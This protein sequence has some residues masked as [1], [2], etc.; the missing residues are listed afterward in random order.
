MGKNVEIKA[1]CS[2]LVTVAKKIEENGGMF[3]SAA[4]SRQTDVYLHATSGRLKIRFHDGEGAQRAEVIQYERENIPGQKSAS[5]QVQPLPPEAARILTSCLGQKTIV[6]KTRD[7]YRN[8]RTK[9]QL[10]TISGLGTF[11]EIEVI[12]EIGDVPTEE[13]TAEC[14]LRMAQL[15]VVQTDLIAC[16]YSDILLAQEVVGAED[17]DEA[18]QGFCEKVGAAL[19]VAG[20]TTAGLFCDHACYRTESAGEYELL[21]LR[22]RANGRLL[23]ETMVGGR[24]IATF[25]LTKPIET[26]FGPIDVIELPRP[27]NGSPYKRGFEHLEFVMDG[28]FENLKTRFPEAK[29]DESGRAKT[30]NPDISVNLQEGM[31]VKFHEASLEDVIKKYG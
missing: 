18:L 14:S 12:D 5:F 13:L 11:V 19:P 31:N 21:K 28:G 25:K 1:F 10:D 9:F 7:I 8:G 4:S 16:S 20:I 30:V 24:P 29:W 6:K 2:D 15:G 17:F 23:T 3:D 26:I 22:L 27:K